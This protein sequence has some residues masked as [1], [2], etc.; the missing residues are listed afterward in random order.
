[1]RAQY[2][3][4]APSDQLDCCI[5][6]CYGRHF[7]EVLSLFTS[8]VSSSIWTTYFINTVSWNMVPSEKLEEISICHACMYSIYKSI[9]AML[10]G[11][12]NRDWLETFVCYK[13]YASKG[14]SFQWAGCLGLILCNVT[15]KMLFWGLC[16]VKYSPSA[17]AFTSSLCLLT[18]QYST[19]DSF[20]FFFR[21]PPAFLKRAGI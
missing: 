3:M 18:A 15:V 10:Q 6:V 4:Y 9:Y 8:V 20:I 16:Y 7:L 14:S 5:T 12:I 13:V 17:F 19:L 1:M 21:L 2:I 11:W